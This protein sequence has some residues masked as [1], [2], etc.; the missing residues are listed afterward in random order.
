MQILPHWHRY[1]FKTNKIKPIWG[2]GIFWLDT[3][4][5]IPVS[6]K[7]L[8]VLSL[9]PWHLFMTAQLIRSAASS[10]CS[11]QPASYSYHQQLF[12]L[13]RTNEKLWGKLCSP[14]SRGKA[15]FERLK[16]Y[17]VCLTAW[18]LVLVVVGFVWF[19]F[20]FLVLSLQPK[21]QHKGHLAYSQTCRNSE[22]Y[23]SGNSFI[24]YKSRALLSWSCT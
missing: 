8:P 1:L 16:N 10:C 7:N 5:N 23:L 6:N 14:P 22:L 9:I 24:T 3:F 19:W 4:Y 2:E 11:V 17:T 12:L 18:Y 21:W 13:F 15:S 20:V